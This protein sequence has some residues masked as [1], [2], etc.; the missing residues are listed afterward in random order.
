MIYSLMLTCRANDVEPYGYLLHVLEE[1]PQRA[2]SADISDLLPFNYAK[3]Q[4]TVK[5]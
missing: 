4:R 2:T 1:L 5:P 3:Q